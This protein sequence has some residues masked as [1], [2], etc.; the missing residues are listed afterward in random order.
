LIATD[1]LKILKNDFSRN[2]M[3]RRNYIDNVTENQTSAL[4][5]QIK[6]NINLIEIII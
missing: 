6:I 4:S 1:T 3:G 2:L 5:N